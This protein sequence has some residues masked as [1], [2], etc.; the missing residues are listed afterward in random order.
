MRWLSHQKKPIK[1][2][3]IIM[4]F[5]VFLFLAII[6]YLEATNNS[7]F[8]SM[9]HYFVGDTESE[10]TVDEVISYEKQ[11][12]KDENLDEGV[13]EI[14]QE[15][16]DG[17]KK[18]IFRVTNDKD[19]NEINRTFIREEIVAEAVDEIIAIGTKTPT[20]TNNNPSQNNNSQQAN[21]QQYSSNGNS[22]P[23]NNNSQSSNN[24]GNNSNPSGGNTSSIHYCTSPGTAGWSGRYWRK[25]YIK[26]NR[27]CNELYGKISG[28]TVEISSEEYHSYSVCNVQFG[29]TDEVLETR[30]TDCGS[31]YSGPDPSCKTY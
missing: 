12:I 9:S 3:I 5:V 13:T 8:E 18:I 25:Y 28:Y 21:N 17:K 7:L 4:M 15:G 23:S 10:I 1:I 27:P 16:K 22:Q 24:S 26:T 11:E 20:P 19:G 6:I 30:C 14:R 29:P 31:D 2:F